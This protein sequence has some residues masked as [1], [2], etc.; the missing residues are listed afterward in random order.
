M[1]RPSTAGLAGVVAGQT[2]LSTVGK[3]G[4]GLTYR[5]YP[6][7][8]L[9]AKAGFEEVAWLLLQGELPNQLQLDAFKRSLHA[10]SSPPTR[11]HPALSAAVS[12]SD[13]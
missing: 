9:A 11:L 2:A 13:S 7:E 1:S 4:V 5:G 3:D 6:I 12:T 8:D 10:S